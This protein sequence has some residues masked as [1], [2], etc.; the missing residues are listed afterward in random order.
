M[1]EQGQGS[2]FA[3]RCSVFIE[4]GSVIFAHTYLFKKLESHPFWASV[5]ALAIWI[6]GWWVIE[7]TLTWRIRRRRDVEKFKGSWGAVVT[8]SSA[9]V[10]RISILKISIPDGRLKVEGVSMER[11]A[12]SAQYRKRHGTW[13][14][15]AI[16]Y[17]KS[18]LFYE[19]LTDTDKD[20]ATSGLCSYTFKTA[21]DNRRLEAYS[22]YFYG[23]GKEP[24]LKVDGYRLSSE[25]NLDGSN[26]ADLARDIETHFQLRGHPE[27]AR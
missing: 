18:T 11:D 10:K 13:H 4:T 21:E 20:G 8:T 27:F 5:G 7:K 2:T 24:G 23:H 6:F 25:V 3:E 9:D 12:N 14:S 26:V 1:V 19:F 22:G 15:Q 16:A 17:E